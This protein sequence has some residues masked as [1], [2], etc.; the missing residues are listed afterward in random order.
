MYI[1]SVNQKVSN[2]FLFFSNK[3]VDLYCNCVTIYV[4]LEN[5]RSR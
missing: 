2:V 4:Q 1:V 5:R 3:K